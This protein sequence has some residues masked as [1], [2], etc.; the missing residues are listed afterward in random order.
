MENTFIS[1]L[2]FENSSGDDD[3]GKEDEEDEAVKLQ[4]S[5]IQRLPTQRR[6]RSSL[7]RHGN[8]VGDEGTEMRVV[9]VGHLSAIE[10]RQF[11]ESLI[12]SVTKDNRRL[13]EKMKGRLKRVG[14][15]LPTTE[16]R[17]NN[18]TVAAR[19]KV[20]AGKPLPTVW[21]AVKEFLAGF[22]NACGLKREVNVSILNGVSGIIKPSRMTL[23]L[24]AP[25]CGKTTLLL[26]LAGKGSQLLE[27]TGEVTYND[28]KLEEFK[29]IKTAAYISQHDQHVPEMTV[30]ETL[31]FSVRCQGVGCRTDMM[32]EV[33]RLEKQAQIV[34]NPD[35]DTY[36][37]AISVKGLQENLQTDYILKLLG[38]ETCSGSMVGDAIRRGISGG[39]K[40]RVTIGEMMVGPSRVFYMDEISNGLD[41]S[42]T[43]QIISCIQQ[44][45]QITEITALISLLQPTPETFNLFD[46]IIL[47]EKGKIVYH[48]PR[49]L[50]LNFFEDCGFKCPPR[51]G[52]ADFLQEIMSEKDQ[53]QYW[54]HKEKPYCYVTTDNFCKKF[55]SSNI[56]KE[57]A[58]EL[59]KLHDT[60]H[61]NENV[62]SFNPHSITKWE[63]F[64]TCMDREFLL[65]K[66]NSFVYIFKTVQITILAII[67]VTA[68]LQTKND[69]NLVNASYITSSLRYAVIRFM[70]NG[71]AELT[72]TI[73]RLPVFYKHRDLHF[74]PI[75]AYSI[76][77][78]L[79]KLP[80]S[81]VE[82]FLWTAITYYGIGYSHG[83]K[84]FLCQFLI[85]LGLHQASTSIFRFLAS[86]TRR[87]H[88][89]VLLGVLT[90]LFVFMFSG[91][92][93]PRNS[94]PTW[95]HWV[96]WFSPA[97]YANIGLSVNEFQ[98]PRWQKLLSTNETLGQQILR[99]QGT[100]YKSFF[101]WLSV[102]ALFVFTILLNIGITV[103]LA[104]LNNPGSSKATISIQKQR[105]EGE[106]PNITRQ[107]ESMSAKG[108][109][110]NSFT[111][112]RM[113]IPF[114]P[115]TMTFQE[116]QYFIEM[117]KKMNEQGFRPRRLQL[118]KDV[119]GAFR[120]GVL[121]A[122]MGVSGAGKTTLMDVLCGRKTSGFI[123]GDLKI[124]GYPK[125]QETFAK[126]SGY[127]EQNDI[128]S[129]QI[130]VEESV[131]YSA[132]L[133][134]P[135]DIDSQTKNEFVQLV[136]E[137]VELDT[138]KDALVGIPGINGLSTEQ[139]KRLTIAV[140]L[141][142]N[143]SI[144][145]MDEPTSGLDARA[146]A[147]IMRAVK[148][149]VETGRTVVC[150][151]HQPSIDIFESFDELL[152]MKKGGQIIFDGPLGQNSRMLV[153]YFENIAG[154]PKIKDYTNPATWMLEITSTTMERRLGIDFA[155][156]YK[157]SSLHLERKALVEKLSTPPQGPSASKI[158]EHQSHNRFFQLKACFWKLSMSY[159]RSPTYILARFAFMVISSLLFAVLFWQRGNKIY[160]EQDVTSI[161]GLMYITT[162]F[163]GINN[164][165]S[166]LPIIARERLVF[167][168][169]RFAGMYSS[170]I[171]SLA[172][173]LVEIPCIL[174]L[175]VT[176]TIITYPTIGYSWSAYKI[177]WYFYFVFCTLL[178]Y[179]YLGMMIMSLT[180]NVQVGAVTASACYAI[181]NLFSGFIIP[182]P[183][184]PRW[185][186]WLYTVCPT[187]WT[188]NG[189]LTSQFGDVST[190]ISAFGETKALD[191]YLKDYYGFHHNQ[192]NLVGFVI[193]CFPISF[194]C[195]FMYFTT[196]R[197]FQRK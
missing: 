24:G 179:N 48:G 34:P 150:T 64:K 142:A 45:V 133:R 103:A 25:G 145:F 191:A 155:D 123:E 55:Q 135:K 166:V 167:Y 170:Y 182:K 148:S 178:Y 72:L 96:F 105:L 59:A 175:A 20:V 158:R 41:S 101:Y 3:A 139:R 98:A 124:G 5:A 112:E 54:Y 30:K 57:L 185:W 35:L 109:T 197:N 189:L 188:L 169:E 187:S 22:S 62:V 16:V 130:T 152:L 122:L 84:R 73:A 183:H 42:T 81:V 78:A 173:I 115:F 56:G 4:W 49:E 10:R 23:L 18:L 126:I 114:Q 50:I 168:R 26:S 141:V 61:S 147:I 93:M 184:I 31:D 165:S 131:M 91:F 108:S 85:Y 192:L 164:C 32:V 40:R 116:I 196:K 174:S 159:W 8:G 156:F 190:D 66:R 2:S 63:L 80:F 94:L 38:L 181:F 97:T 87:P 154:I 69:V 106:N 77:S 33:E 79:L 92:I 110:S 46:D 136:L 195:L 186:I 176:Y 29:P 118:L 194:A 95:L 132:W 51:K 113:I 140:E 65:L 13:L 193:A 75:W 121:T 137:T 111:K 76:P 17:F 37:K 107:W 21:N 67:T 11:V 60:A 125:V 163:L 100:D 83:L 180:P 19:C 138:I 6:L 44:L 47:M 153:E 177:M 36:M 88:T 28:M 171:Y 58:K 52:V 146:A 14:V 104:Y 15:K 151:I 89:A 120:P 134:L 129:S 86:I 7:F 160:N 12:S 172:Q 149:I 27:V 99:S 43:F 128:H 127:C 39:Q 9:D 117:P 71:I 70:T 102:V 144:I 162:I 161:M 68:F 90:L 74:H 53:A 157:K 143:P 82:S 1:S 119:T